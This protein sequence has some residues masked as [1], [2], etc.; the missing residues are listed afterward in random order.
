MRIAY[1]GLIL[2]ISQFVWIGG[3]DLEIEGTWEWNNKCAMEYDNFKPGEPNNGGEHEHC[4]I[5]RPW[6]NCKWNDDACSELLNHF[7]CNSLVVYC[8]LTI[9][10]L[11]MRT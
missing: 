10:V 2:Y 7:F 6:W 8:T 1:I 4:A 3:N 5:V 9:V 11:I